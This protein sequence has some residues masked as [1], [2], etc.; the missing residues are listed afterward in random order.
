MRCNILLILYTAHH[1]TEPHST[2]QHIASIVCYTRNNNQPIDI[3]FQWAMQES[4]LKHSFVIQQIDD[5]PCPALPC[6][7][8][9]CAIHIRTHHDRRYARQSASP[10]TR[11]RV[12]RTATCGLPLPQSEPQLGCGVCPVSASGRAERCQRHLDAKRACTGRS[13][14]P[15]TPSTSYACRERPAQPRRKAGR[16]DGQLAQLQSPT[17]QAESQGPL[18]THRVRSLANAFESSKIPSICPDLTL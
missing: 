3:S 15:K 16:G 5:Q 8:L 10:C 17:F 9:P 12:P 14:L 13:M 11:E 6:F 18:T 2:G 1:S 4:A 7:A